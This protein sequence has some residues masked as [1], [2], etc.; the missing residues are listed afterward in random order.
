MSFEKISPRDIKENAFDLIGSKWMLITAGDETKCNTMTA[1]WGGVGVLWNW[2][3]TTCYIRPTRYTYEFIEKEDYYTLSFFGEEYRKALGVCGSKSGRD[4]DKIKEC[5][6]TVKYADCGTPYFEEAE[7]VI[8]C[9][10]VYYDDFKPENFLD[11]KI[12]GNY[13]DDYHRI[14]I[15]RI[16]EV[17]KKV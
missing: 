11:E 14:Y 12:A 15:G 6:F 7:T 9:K 1:S 4:C 3:V 16:E 2:D 5:G 10:K 8:V 13:S 17:L